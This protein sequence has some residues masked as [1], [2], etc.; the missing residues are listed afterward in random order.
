MMVVA[1]LD[2][3]LHTVPAMV[4]LTSFMLALLDWIERDESRGEKK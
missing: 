4:T 3:T 2:E 1:L